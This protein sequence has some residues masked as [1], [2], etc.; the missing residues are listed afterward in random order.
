MKQ[1]SALIAES[2]AVLVDMDGCL[3]AGQHVLPGAADL[4]KQAADK[5]WLVSNNSSHSA[6]ELSL[7]L[8]ALGLSVAPQQMLLAGE[9]VLA[10]ARHC[11]PSQGLML[12]ARQ[13]LRTYAARLGIVED[14]DKPAAI[15]LTRDTDLCYQRLSLA[16]KHLSRGVPLL[17]SN[18]DFS[19]P[20]LDGDPVP[21]TGSLLA[22]LTSII[23]QLQYRV[24]GKPEAGLFQRA[25]LKANADPCNSLMIGDNPRTDRDG[26]EALGIRAF[27]VGHHPEA[28]AINLNVLLNK[29]LS[30]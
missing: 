5:F 1:F 30:D 17:V 26:A 15:V 6:V 4:I 3:I 28:D 23:P 20:D 25:L 7:R 14:D 16:I 9:A 21:E 29:T 8:A 27:L 10:E 11:Y 19:H 2:D 24:L 18:P 12:L 13:E 22:L